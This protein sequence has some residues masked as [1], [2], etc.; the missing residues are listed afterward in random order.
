[1]SELIDRT[2]RTVKRISAELRPGVLDDLGL[3]AAVEWQAEEFQS[4][5]GIKCEVSSKP[6]DVVL[7]QDLATQIFRIFQEALTNVSRHANATR[8]KISLEERAGKLVLKVS[9]NGKGI[10]QEQITNPKSFGLMGISERARSQ[11]GK[12]KISG[13]KGKGT[14]VTVT[15]PLDGRK[16]TR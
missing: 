12:A 16:E 9:D 7:D 13:I 3:M 5:T 15:I 10:T 8:V 1:M 4:R 11:R 14:T 2:I 6:T